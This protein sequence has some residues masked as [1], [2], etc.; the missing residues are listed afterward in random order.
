MRSFLT[1]LSDCYN[2][3]SV[4]I[5]ALCNVDNSKVIESST[6]FRKV[7][8]STI[9]KGGYRLAGEIV[10]PLTYPQELSTMLITCGK[11]SLSYPQPPITGS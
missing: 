10:H 7:D 9:I 8:K 3:T 6:I 2:R 4:L 5:V 11:L 1:S